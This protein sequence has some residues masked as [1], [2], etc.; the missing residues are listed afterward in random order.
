MKSSKIFLLSGLSL[1]ITAACSHQNDYS[2][3]PDATG[4]KI[5][6]EAC[7]N[8][9]QPDSDGIIYTL[10]KENANLDAIRQ[11]I[12]RGSLMMPKFPNMSEDAINKVGK[13]V[14]AHSRSE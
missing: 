4:E 13:Y 1:L 3:S 12:R 6:A 11:Q 10:K 8:C 9:H 14:L 2:P 7:Q 5:F